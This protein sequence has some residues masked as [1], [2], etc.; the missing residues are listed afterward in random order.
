MLVSNKRRDPTIQPTASYYCV[1]FLHKASLHCCTDSWQ[2][3]IVVAPTHSPMPCSLTSRLSAPDRHHTRLAFLMKVKDIVCKKSE[4][5]SQQNFG[6][7]HWKCQ[8][9]IESTVDENVFIM[10]QFS[11]AITALV[12]AI[13]YQQTNILDWPACQI[14]WERSKCT[15]SYW[16]LPNIHIFVSECVQEPILIRCYRWR[17]CILS[18]TLRLYL[19]Q[20]VCVS[21]CKFVHIALYI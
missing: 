13:K 19:Y 16:T 18:L 1:N 3:R 20:C 9:Y 21:T 4:W 8:E 5:C 12:S 17:P 15:I 14:W 10:F 6:K 2:R 11:T 7:S